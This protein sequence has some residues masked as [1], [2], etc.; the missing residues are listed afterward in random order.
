MSAGQKSRYINIRYIWIKDQTKE[1]EIDVR[2]CPT[3]SMLSDF[4]T[5]PLNGSLFQKFRD[6]ILGYKPVSS[7][8]E[9]LPPDVEEHVGNND[10]RL[11]G[12]YNVSQSDTS[13]Y[14]GVTRD[15]AIEAGKE[16]SM[17]IN[18]RSNDEF[19]KSNESC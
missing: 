8:R 19:I 14:K 2:H 1:L 18:I 13:K 10:Q 16:D 9:I 4:F 6:V 15:V 7:L 5:K 17:K 12:R 11:L 3:L